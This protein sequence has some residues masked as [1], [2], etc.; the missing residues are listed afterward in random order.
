M[1]EENEAVAIAR[2]KCVNFL[3]IVRIISEDGDAH[4]ILL[5]LGQM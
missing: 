3:A 1:G 2:S 4:F 5:A